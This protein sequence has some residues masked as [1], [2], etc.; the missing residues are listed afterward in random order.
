M[1]VARGLV[2]GGLGDF[3]PGQLGR[4]NRIGLLPRLL[5]LGGMFGLCAPMASQ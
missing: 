2:T 1:G 4:C 5:G 3:Q